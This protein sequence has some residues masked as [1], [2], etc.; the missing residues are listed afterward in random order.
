MVRRTAVVGAAVVV[1]AAAGVAVAVTAGR[2]DPLSGGDPVASG[3]TPSPTSS[4][5]R[6]TTTTATGP[7]PPAS[8][9]GAPTSAATI[10]PDPRGADG[11][12]PGEPGTSTPPGAN[13]EVTVSYAGWDPTTQRVQVNAFAAVLENGG[14]CTLTLSDAAGADQRSSTAP[15]SADATTTICDQLTIDSTTMAPGTWTATVT[16]SSPTHQGRSA[17]SDVVVTR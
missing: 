2:G 12:R 8:S 14:T 11:A 5:A 4:L 1:V 7:P 13:A 16:Y 15:A 6:T 10:T 9:M 3:R 17:G